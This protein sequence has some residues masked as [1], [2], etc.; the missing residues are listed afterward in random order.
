[1]R[2]VRRI[3]NA[4]TNE[5]G[6][7]PSLTHWFNVDNY[8]RDPHFFVPRLSRFRFFALIMSYIRHKIGEAAEVAMSILGTPLPGCF[9]SYVKTASRFYRLGL[10]SVLWGSSHLCSATI[11]VSILSRT[12]LCFDPREV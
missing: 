2:P 7:S 9:W 12:A 1:M 3:G 11:S 6:T 5:T 10:P 4:Q 8:Y